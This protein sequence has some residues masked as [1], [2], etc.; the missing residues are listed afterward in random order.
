MS[1][2]QVLQQVQQSVLGG[3]GRV[4]PADSTSLYVGGP[5]LFD[6]RELACLLSHMVA[7]Q[8]LAGALADGHRGASSL[9]HR[10]LLAGYGMDP[11]VQGFN[12]SDASYPDVAQMRCEPDAVVV[13]RV[14]R[15]IR[16][17][18]S[19]G[20]A[21]SVFAVRHCCNNPRCGNTSGPSDKALV[22]GSG[23]LCAGCKVARYCVSRPVSRCAGH[24]GHTSLCARCCAKA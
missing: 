15:L 11:I 18:V 19:L 20:E 6:G 16:T 8:E 10:L 1:S 13:E 3:S 22:S 9:A 21:L 7:V 2:G 14:G 5:W 12:T 24:K 23:C 17:L 4:I